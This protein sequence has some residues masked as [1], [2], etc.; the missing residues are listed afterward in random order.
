[1]AEVLPRSGEYWRSGDTVRTRYTTDSSTEDYLR[2]DGLETTV[3]NFRKADG[4]KDASGSVQHLFLHRRTLGFCDV[5][6]LSMLSFDFGE[7][8]VTLAD[9]LEQPRIKLRGAE[10][11]GG[12]FAVRMTNERGEEIDVWLDPAVNYLVRKKVVSSTSKDGT[13][14]Q[15]ETE[16][17]SFVEPAP[18]IFF[19]SRVTVRHTTNGKLADQSTYEFSAIRI[20]QPLPADAFQV[21]YV[22]GMLFLNYVQ[23]KVYHV[24]EGGRFLKASRFHLSKRPPRGDTTRNG[25]DADSDS[26]GQA[27]E[28]EPSSSAARW[29]LLASAV[30]L[31]TAGVL[32]FMRRR[33]SL[34]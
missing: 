26:P 9:F 18:G 10:Q 11:D 16:V 22:N 24:D 15:G 3:T 12:L 19:P 2:R 25:S 29:I 33:R 34:A 5:W 30:T 32:W 7:P 28:E 27:T 1:M 14:L 13:K 6:Y 23:N 31:V 4:R 17:E 8:A 20:N 21:K